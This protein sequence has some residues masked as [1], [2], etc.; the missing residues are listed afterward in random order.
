MS[1]YRQILKQAWWLT[2][3]NR[4]LWWFGVFAALLGN[5]GE[6]EILFN[7]TSG[8]PSQGLLP[9]W[10]GIASTGL[11]SAKTYGNIG[12]L[13][14]HDTLNLLM[15]FTIALISL[16]IFIF[17]V[18]LALVSQAAIVSSAAAFLEQ[19]KNSFRDSLSAGILNF[20][21]VLSLNILLRALISLLVAAV[22]LL[23]FL[24]SENFYGKALYGLAL[25]ITALLA[26]TL[27]FIVKYAIAYVVVRRRKIGQALK[28]SWRLFRENWLVSLEMA[29]I[30]FFINILVGLVITLTIL[31]LAVPFLFL[32]L[33]FYY[34]FSSFGAWL[35]AVLAF[36]VFLFIIIS[37]GA[38]LA[39]FQ[40]VSWISLFLKIEKDR[41]V[42]KLVRMA[43]GLIKA[44]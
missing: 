16:A 5:G 39:V 23:A 17:L 38:A 40:L 42:S 34:S 18:W 41:N 20:W 19:K 37:I 24:W 32:G 10:R 1:F 13:F 8:N 6:L 3:R 9:F 22:S 2:W 35:I 28:Q 21:P 27:S 11:F 43:K 44:N 4:H 29:L 30:L 31:T 15:V 25:F 7:N 33:I 14:K 36:V 26:I 12:N